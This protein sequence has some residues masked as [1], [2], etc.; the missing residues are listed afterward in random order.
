M[1]FFLSQEKRGLMELCLF[2]EE[3]GLMEFSL[4]PKLWGRG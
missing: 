2:Q 3:R 1:E 4:S